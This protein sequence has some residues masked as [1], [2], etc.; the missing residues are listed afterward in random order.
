M[1][2]FFGASLL[3]ATMAAFAQP[4]TNSAKP[5]AVASPVFRET[6]LSVGDVNQGQKVTHSFVF[7]NAGDAELRVKAVTPT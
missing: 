1:Q 5:Q 6:R 3:V 7:S 2:L 4:Q